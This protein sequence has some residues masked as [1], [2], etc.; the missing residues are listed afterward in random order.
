M[1]LQPVAALADLPVGGVLAVEIDGVDVALVRDED[2]VYA[3][4]DECSHAA[5]PLSGGDV[6]VGGGRCEIECWLHGSNF[7]VRTGKPTNLPATT[8][9]PTYPTRVDGDTVLVDL[10]P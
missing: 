8:P 9:V 6:T 4:R 7:D 1:S 5:V 3:L 10:T 2:G